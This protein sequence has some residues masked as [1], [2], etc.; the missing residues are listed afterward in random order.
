MK[1]FT[2]VVKNNKACFHNMKLIQFTAV[3]LMIGLSLKLLLLPRRVEENC[4]TGRSRWLMFGGIALLGIQFFLQM[5]LGLRALGVTQ[6]V[7]LNLTVFTLVSWLLSQ[8][9]LYLQRQGRL[10]FMEQWLGGAVWLVEMVMIGTVVIT[11][12]EPVFFDISRLQTVEQVGSVL[13]FAMQCFYSAKEVIQLRRMHHSLDDY[14]DYD[15]GQRL[16][17]MQVSIFVLAALALFVPAAIFAPGRWL[18]GFSVVFFYG[19]WYL[20]DSFCDYVKSSMPQKVA[21]SEKTTAASAEKP[22]QE[23]DA[24]GQE[25]VEV[26]IAKWIDKGGHLKSGL[27]K[28]FVAEQ[29]GVSEHQLSLWLRQRNHTFRDWLGDLRIEEAKLVIRKHPD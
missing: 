9:I 10:T 11:V 1:F 14:Y 12:E 8:S 25:R 19:M 29:L 15:L 26:A 21:E 23:M 27:K 7:M 20:V 24:V 3:V 16:Q 2:F 13:Y 28:S 4:V 22:E 18:I 5:A 6:A 17:W